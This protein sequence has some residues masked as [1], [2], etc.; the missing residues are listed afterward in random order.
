M[1]ETKGY[2]VK[3]EVFHNKGSPCADVQGVKACVFLQ[4]LEEGRVTSRAVVRGKT[5]ESDRS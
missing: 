3:T 4:E 2:P 5:R 1:K